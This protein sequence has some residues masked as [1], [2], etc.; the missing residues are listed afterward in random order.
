M[1]E[2][3]SKKT[4]KSDTEESVKKAKKKVIADR[5]PKEIVF[6]AS[7][8]LANAYRPKAL[9]DVY[10]QKAVVAALQGTFKRGKLPNTMLFSGHYGCGKTTMALIYARMANC[11]TADLC[12]KCFSCKFG[13]RHPDIIVHDCGPDGKID[14]IRALISKS[15]ASP[16]TRK[17]F[18]IVDEVHLLR[19]QSEKALLVESENP[20]PNTI[21][22]FCTTNPE[23]LAKTLVSRCLHLVV[24]P[25]PVED[26][27]ARM[28][29]VA[30]LE[31]IPL[32][33]NAK[34]A[35]RT[36]AESSNGSMREALTKLDNFINVLSSGEE[37]D[38]ASIDAFLQGEDADVEKVTAHVIAG[39]LDLNI[40][41]TISAIRQSS[42][43]ARAIISKSRW[44]LDHL[45]GLKT[46]SAKP[47]SPASYKEFATLKVKH[48]LTMLVLVQHMLTELEIKLNSV[49]VDE[50]VTFYS[51]IGA[52]IAE[53]K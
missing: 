46:K 35:I 7:A 31:N 32:K 52:F 14:D 26:L 20:A 43:N 24:R 51:T 39:I 12:G 41:Y 38:P 47:W 22:I 10:G 3:K 28:I 1:A 49:S 16:V 34:K 48:G 53:H 45:I 27:E 5:K 21:W 23:K 11:V 36:I 29:Q 9:K 25:I 2:K 4:F 8:N 44:L 42:G 37:Y 13:A 6:A 40:E 19:D 30:E 33:K 15:K 50:A 18:I 17:R